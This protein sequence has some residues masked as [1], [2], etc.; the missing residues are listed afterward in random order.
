[1]QCRKKLC[2]YPCGVEILFV[3]EFFVLWPFPAA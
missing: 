1:M 3:S 2:I